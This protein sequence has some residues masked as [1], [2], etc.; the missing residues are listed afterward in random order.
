MEYLGPAANTDPQL[1]TEGHLVLMKVDPLPPGTVVVA[2][3]TIPGEKQ[4][5]VIV[6]REALLRHEGETFVY[7]QVGDYVFHRE[8][9]SLDRPTGD[10]W[11]VSKDLKPEDRV[12]VVGSQQLLSEELKGQG[13]G[14]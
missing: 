4:S 6:P 2:W 11:F 7:L 1:Q 14:E 10:G 8:A 3:L 5:G 13:G 12:V 9:V